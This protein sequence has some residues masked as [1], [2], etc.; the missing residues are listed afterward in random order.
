MDVPDDS[1][2]ASSARKMLPLEAAAGLPQIVLR[3]LN[4]VE[5]AALNAEHIKLPLDI[6][7][8]EVGAGHTPAPQLVADS[9]QS[10]T[11]PSMPAEGTLPFV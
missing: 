8:Y 4:R 11:I 3:E 10:E 7:E 1:A 6:T 5:E 2:S 9:A